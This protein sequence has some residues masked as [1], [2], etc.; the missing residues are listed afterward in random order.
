MAVRVILALVVA[1]LAPLAVR[2]QQT[3]PA[4]KPPSLAA[5]LAGRSL[6]HQ[7]RSL[8]H[9][10]GGAAE[11]KAA[12][13]AVLLKRARKYI[14]ADAELNRRLV[15]L[16]ESF[17]DLTQA[18]AAARRYTAV[19][20][21]DYAAA[22]RWLRVSQSSLQTADQRIVFLKQAAANEKLGPG[23]RSTALALMGALHLRRGDLRAARDI[24][25]EALVLDPYEMLALDVINR[26]EVKPEP[27]QSFRHAL[28]VLGAAPRHMANAWLAAELLQGAGE[29]TR[30][31]TF[32]EHAYAVAKSKRPPP[33][34]MEAMLVGYLNA[35]LDAGQA[36]K[37]VEMF[38]PLMKGRERSL[39]LQALMVEAWR[40]LGKE[41]QAAKHVAEM[42]KVYKAMAAPDARRTG[43]MTAD[44]AWFHLRFRRDLDLALHWAQSAARSHG[45]D[46]QVIR[47][48]GACEL[49][50]GRTDSGVKRLAK[51]AD[52]D[53]YAAAILAKHYYATGKD[54]LAR[55]TML[56]GV[57]DTRSLAPWR[58]LAALAAE[59]KVP[60]PPRKDAPFMRAALDGLSPRALDMGLRPETF[61]SAKLTTAAKE[62]TLGEAIIVTV[63]LQNTSKRSVPVGQGGLF[64]PVVFIGLAVEGDV[65]AAWPELTLEH[66]PAPKHLGPGEKVSAA[67]RI[68]VGPAEKLLLTNPLATLKLTVTAML[69]PLED[70]GKLVSSVPGIKMAPATIRRKA[71]MAPDANEAQVKGVLGRI[72]G[73]LQKG[74]PSVQVRGAWRTAALL[75]L[76]RRA[77]TGKH[78]G[79]LPA[80]LTK[81]IL[82]SMTRAHI[83]SRSSLV[84][85]EMLA[86]LHY[87]D[88]EERIIA[89]LS[90][91]VQDTSALVRMRLIE[92]L[93]AKK[94]K[95]RVTLVDLFINDRDSEVSAM[96]K[97][98]RQGE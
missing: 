6:I 38:A 84:R 14:P 62:V 85:S 19:R 37:A 91:C 72:A 61:I 9:T 97:I 13:I 92:L 4:P 1:L 86:A 64:T 46:P 98:F 74:T 53:T 90:P 35:L 18:A 8:G 51:V 58:A 54:G 48:L 11:E 20:P 22:V 49:A 33:S 2:G 60:L 16:H 69:D 56:G 3:K 66:L 80:A 87:V 52:K 36:A 44:L 39:A 5:R 23:V 21:R 55:Q 77:E 42:A 68:D 32:Y 41:E 70:R 96:A 50:K 93:A 73:D 67:I 17:G 75:A 76:V 63:E 31:L 81:P 25:R 28:R 47:V 59:H 79:P 10:P 40:A 89:L 29:Y 82:L 15:D 12:R 43:Q 65:K 57:G 95:G 30:A 71:L 34:V 83:R 94:T 88:L 24:G 7:G 26:A 45:D 78:K 27:I